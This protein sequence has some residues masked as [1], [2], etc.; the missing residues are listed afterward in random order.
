MH[1]KF[2]SLQFIH[3]NTGNGHCKIYHPVYR[4]HTGTY[5]RNFRGHAKTCF[6]VC[7]SNVRFCFLVHFSNK[8]EP[9]LVRNHFWGKTEF[10]MFLFY[11]QK[12][13][14][15]LLRKWINYYKWPKLRFPTSDLW[16]PVFI[17]FLFSTSWPKLSYVNFGSPH[18]LRCYDFIGISTNICV[19]KM[20][21]SSDVGFSDVKLSHHHL[22][23]ILEN[24]SILAKNEICISLV[25]CGSHPYAISSFC[26]N[27]VGRTVCLT[28]KTQKYNN[29]SC[30][31][32]CHWHFLCTF[33]DI[34]SNTCTLGKTQTSHFAWLDSGTL[35]GNQTF[36]HQTISTPIRFGTKTFRHQICPNVSAPDYNYLVYAKSLLKINFGHKIFIW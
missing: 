30:S 35:R 27:Y 9:G 29:F 33:D 28:I 26:R 13:W 14:K 25:I 36:R 31:V 22:Q 21:T 2:I 24:L 12:E 7:L 32:P 4:Q 5:K 17:P 16:K 19:K 34:I 23:Q 3:N 15:N 20:Q 10:I 11:P 6:Y 1:N 8:I 18:N